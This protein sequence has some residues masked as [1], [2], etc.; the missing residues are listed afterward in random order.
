MKQAGF[1]PV[2]VNYWNSFLFVPIVIRKLLNKDGKNSDLK[3]LPKIL[4]SLLYLILNLETPLVLTGLSL[5]FG[6]SVVGVFQ[7]C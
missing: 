7:K 2:S 5:P 6:T 3:K 1:K 4:N